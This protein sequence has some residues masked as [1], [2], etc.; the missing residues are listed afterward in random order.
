MTAQR[1]CR[2][3]GKAISAKHPSQMFCSPVRGR[4]LCKDRFHNRRRF[5]D[6][7]I[8]EARARFLG[9]GTGALAGY[10]SDGEAFR[11]MCPAMD[12]ESIQGGGQ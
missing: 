2:E 10:D 1:K 7:E 8:T 4:R 12:E 5:R 11:F 3:C 9:G 6:G